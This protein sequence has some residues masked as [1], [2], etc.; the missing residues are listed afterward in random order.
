MRHDADCFTS[1]MSFCS[2][3]SERSVL[4][5]EEDDTS[6]IRTKVR[7]V[8]RQT[9]H[10]WDTYVLASAATRR[11]PRSRVVGRQGRSREY[12]VLK[13]KKLPF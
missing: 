13:R 5:F 4:V 12:K 9:C 7:I 3:L 1:M 11:L 2:A 8:S 6:K 10:Q